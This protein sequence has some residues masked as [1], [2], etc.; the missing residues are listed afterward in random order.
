MVTDS[1]G[2]HHV[3]KARTAISQ[4]RFD[5]A[6]EELDAA[7]RAGDSGPRQLAEIFRLQGEVSASMDLSDAA[8]EHFQQLLALD[9]QASLGDVPPKVSQPFAAA[10]AA[11]AGR[12]PLRVRC[13]I[14]RAPVAAVTLVVEADP[15]AMITG[16][17]AVVRG[18]FHAEQTVEGRAGE[19]MQL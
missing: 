7:L 19:R 6:L 2:H 5:R 13:E 3:E 1:S 15:V 8:V 14:T 18:P 10:K 16:A 11:L 17:R 4:L 9:P 12:P